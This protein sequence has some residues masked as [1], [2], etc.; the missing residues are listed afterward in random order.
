LAKKKGSKTELTDFH[1]FFNRETQWLEFN[2]RVLFQ[3]ESQQTP[4]LERLKFLG[5]YTSNLDEFIM[6]RVGGLKRQVDYGLGRRS[7]D[8]LTAAEQL[9]SIHQFLLEEGR[10]VARLYKEK[11]IPDLAQHHIH[12]KKWNELSDPQKSQ[13]TDYFKSNIFPV[14]TPLVVDNALPFPFISNLSLSLA[15]KL[16]NKLGGEILFGRVKVPKVFP[17]WLEVDEPAE[18]VTY[19]SLLQVISHNLADLFPDMNILKVMPFRITRNAD[20]DR[21]EEGAEDLLDMITEEIRQRRFAEAVRLEVGKNTDPWMVELLKEELELGDN[22]IYEV[23]GLLDYTSL[24]SIAELPLP[25]LKFPNWDPLVLSPFQDTRTPVF[26]LIKQ[27]DQLVHHPYE[28][29]SGSVE[30]FIRSASEDENVLAIKMTLYRT[31][32]NSSII[33]SLIHAAELGKQVVCL[34]ELKARF[35][36]ERNIYWAQQMEKAGIHVVYGVIGFKTHCKTTLVLRKEGKDITAYAHLG[37]GNYNSS[38]ARLYTDVG[39]LTADKEITQDVIQLFH[40]LTSRSFQREFKSLLVAPMNMKERFLELID[41]ELE[42]AKKAQPARIIAKFNSLEDREIINR[43]YEASSAGVKVDLI[44]RG[45]CCLKPG[46]PGLSDNIQVISVIGRFLEHSR[47]FYF[48]NGQLDPLEG[49]FLI[50]SA[51]WMRRNLHGRVEVITPVKDRSLRR[52]L[53]EILEVALDDQS[54]AWKQQSDGTYVLKGEAGLGSQEQLM[55]L[56][57][58]RCQLFEDNS[59]S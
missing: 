33:S 24:F 22:D 59:K 27:N 42:A 58:A 3:A 7:H 31:N 29:F 55:R 49:E 41:R 46:V 30:R 23:S 40:F 50:G 6:K 1:H 4:L 53:Y 54:H 12:L 20:L 26:D 47:I 8:G 45:F 37:T 11:I 48:Q 14:L 52:K 17:Q 16:E 9:S 21:D 44:V 56:T 2:K 34:V 18:G 35:D 28:S 19:V 15:I 36:E 38:T 10:R 25:H 32:K 5:I 51:D 43:L 39:L 13:L 57:Q